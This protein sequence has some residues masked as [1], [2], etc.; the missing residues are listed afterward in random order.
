MNA[1]NEK[2]W[3]ENDLTTTAALLLCNEGVSL[4]R[5]TFKD[6]TSGIKL[7]WLSPREKAER[8][9][10]KYLSG[11]I[12]LNPLELRDRINSLRALRAEKEGNP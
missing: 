8:I 5:V 11:L 6:G 9:Y 1:Q 10:Y 4:E 12:R 2:F 7:F 3:I